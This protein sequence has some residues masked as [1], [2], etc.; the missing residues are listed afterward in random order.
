M[1]VRSRREGDSIRIL[2][3]NG[4]KTLKKLFIEQRIPVRE[5]ALIPVIADD[6]GV[7]AIYGI[8]AGSRAVPEPGDQATLIN[9]TSEGGQD[10]E[11]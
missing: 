7:L 6:N 1:T 2:G 11:R 5:R 8:G 3:K 9:F 10:D 4:T